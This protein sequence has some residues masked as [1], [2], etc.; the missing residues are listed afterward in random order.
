MRTQKAL[1]AICAH[2][3]FQQPADAASHPT[4]S[5]PMHSLISPVPLS[6]SRMQRVGPTTHAAFRVRAPEPLEL[7]L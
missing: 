3:F 4:R 1:T 5:A 7:A 6:L 2:A